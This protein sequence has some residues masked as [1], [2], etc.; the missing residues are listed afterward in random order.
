M[1]PSGKRLVPFLLAVMA[2]SLAGLLSVYWAGLR[3]SAA[4]VK[5]AVSR[6]IINGLKDELYALELAQSCERGFLLTGD[7]K[8]TQPYDAAVRRV[9]ADLRRLEAWARAREVGAADAEAVILLTREKLDELKLT[10]ELRRG[11]DWQRAL[12]GLRSDIGPQITAALWAEGAV[13]STPG[14]EAALAVVR[15]DLSK[16]VTNHLRAH[17]DALENGEQ[18]DIDFWRLQRNEANRLRLGLAVAVGAVD[19]AFLA[20]LLRRLARARAAAESSA[21]ETRQQKD[22]LA[23]TLASIGDAVIITDAHGR[24][25][26]LNGEAERLTGWPKQESIGQ[27]LPTVFHIVNEQTRRPVQNPVEMVLLL[28]RVASLADHT[29]L[30][31]RDGRQIPID[32]SGAPIRQAGGPAHG[33]V[34][35]FRDCTERKAAERELRESEQRFRTLA[36][37]MPQLAWIAHADGWVYWYN[38]RWYEYTGTTPQQMEGWGWQ[39]VHDPQTLPTVL[40]RWKA[41]LASGAPLDMTCPLRGADGVFRPFLTRAMPLKDSQGRVV[42]W[43]GTSTDISEQKATEAALAAAKLS[44]DRAQAAAED[45]NRAKDHFLAVLSHELR[46][47]LTPVVTALSMLQQKGVPDPEARESLELI[48]RNVKLETRLIDDLLDMTRVARGKIDLDRKPTDLIAVI[49]RAV[50]VCLPDIKAR[51]LE[52]GLD[53]KDAPC[54]VDA[55]ATRLQQVFW[56]ILRNAIKFTPPGGRVGIRCRRAAETAVV[57]ISDSGEGIEPHVL[58][59]IFNA[60]EQAESSIT[61]QFG[62]VGLGLTISKALVDLHGGTIEAESP[63]K[64]KGSTFRVRLPIVAAEPVPAPP[65]QRP[66]PPIRALRILLVE[67]HADT[68]NVIRHL[69]MFEGHQVEL[70]GDVATALDALGSSTFDLLISDLGLP[71]R[72]GLELMRELRSRGNAMPGIALSGYGQQEDICRSKAA[73]FA[74]HLTKPASPDKLAEAIAGAVGPGTSKR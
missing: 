27:P 73:G 43:F 53:A 30:V 68:A 22:L 34:L 4:E 7:E 6:E 57:E 46:T 3:V 40:A 64:G 48:H 21:A 56:N 63:G 58:P 10:I 38:I 62:G 44:A 16:Q 50:E 26:F 51:R 8:Y 67:D 39:S 20:W 31:A 61:R 36:D 28:G 74:A 5:L 54:I 25:T 49:R 69:L 35:V 14:P 47:P 55:D 42:Q 13:P 33:V 66:P 11:E 60:F 9:H 19:L 59:R 45:A 41:S 23:V 17:L 15:L 72:S 1:T 65:A 29:I 71:D 70:A 12:V 18:H 2:L 24:V 52:F 32:D 37:A